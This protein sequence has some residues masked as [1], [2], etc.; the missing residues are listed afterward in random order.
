MQLFRV[1]E[2]FSQRRLD[3]AGQ[4]RYAILI[5]LAIQDQYLASGKVHYGGATALFVARRYPELVR[6]LVLAEPA[7]G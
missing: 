2:L 6:S 4:Y 5:D 1:L 3:R 7:V